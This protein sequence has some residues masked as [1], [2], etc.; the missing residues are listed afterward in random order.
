MSVAVIPP[1]AIALLR[2][3]RDRL[4][5]RHAHPSPSEY[6]TIDNPLEVPCQVEAYLLCRDKYLKPSDIVLDVGFGLGYGL[7]IMAAKVMN[8]VG[9]EVDAKTLGRARRIFKRHSRIKEVCLY[10]GKSIP[11]KDKTFDVVT[12]VEILEHV[13]DYKGLLLEMIRVSRR[14]LF[15]STPN[16]RSKYTLPDGR[17]KNYWHL[18][19]W[20]YEEFDSILQQIPDVRVDWNFL[21]G[22]WN[23]PFEYS[24]VISK[25]TLSLIPVLMLITSQEQKSNKH[26]KK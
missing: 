16:R 10:D 21:N 20:R 14:L 18:R 26:F 19:E 5:H 2:S 12:C 3:I 7:H 17:P 24:S 23:G 22:L 9:L 13:E 15:I 8:L 25:D 1:I 6:S 4:L 11:F